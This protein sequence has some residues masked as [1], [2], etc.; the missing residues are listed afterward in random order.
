MPD[1]TIRKATHADLPALGRLGATLMRVHYAFDPHR[2]MP[3]GPEAPDGYA[4][5]LG[6]QLREKDVVVLVAERAGEVVGYVYA[7]IEPR[8]W[9]ELRWERSGRGADGSGAGLAE[10]R[11]HAPSGA[12][13]RGPER[14]GSAA[15]LPPRFQTDDGRNDKGAHTGCPR[16]RRM[17]RKMTAGAG[18]SPE[19][20]TA[21]PRT[22]A[23]RPLAP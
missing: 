6:T 12:L 14:R 20:R 5:F 16:I 8:N 13:D 18:G 7:G 10:R 2:F 1:F 19:P 4:W 22:C 3:A 11:G 17:S 23:P 9:K 21:H 15:V